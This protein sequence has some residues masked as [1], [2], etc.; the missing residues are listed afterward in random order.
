M[1]V[2]LGNARSPRD[3]SRP[4]VQQE[5]KVLALGPDGS[6]GKLLPMTELP[7]GFFQQVAF[8][9][10]E[11][12]GRIVGKSAS[13]LTLIR[14]KSG[15]CVSVDKANSTIDGRARDPNEMSRVLIYG[16][17]EAVSLCARMIQ[18]VVQ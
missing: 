3:M 17:V 10:K 5:Q 7:D 13:V 8:V 18:E 11:C 14:S 1:F 15:A 6:A 12:T 2:T 16:T 9:Q 4:P